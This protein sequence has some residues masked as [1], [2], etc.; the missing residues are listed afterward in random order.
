MSD[1]SNPY[2]MPQS[3]SLETADDENT[4]GMGKSYPLPE[5][6]KGWSWG[7]FLLNWIWSIGNKTW[8]GLI[9]LIPYV[10]IV[11]AIV[12][13]INGREWAWQNKRW[14]DLDHFNRVQRRWSIWAACLVFIPTIGIVAAVALPA[15]QDYTM[16]ARLV[17][18]IKAANEAA[19]AVGN[20]VYANH[21]LPSTLQEAGFTAPVLA[22]LDAISINQKTGLLSIT[23]N[24]RSIQGK[25]F[26]LAPSVEHDGK[27][28]WRCMYGEIRKAYFPSQCRYDT[29]D[30]FH[31]P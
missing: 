30:E 28:V 2:D 24:I 23:T 5:G 15:Y 11:M 3:S 12:L 7:A 22:D 17:P 14:D 16:R 8:I 27:V 25:A 18:V 20:Y 31:L 21:A 13:G 19:A 29:A 9:A 26:F 1:V 6:V 4:S 10:G